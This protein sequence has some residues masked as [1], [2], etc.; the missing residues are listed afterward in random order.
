MQRTSRPGGCN[1]RSSFFANSSKPSGYIG[2]PWLSAGPVRLANRVQRQPHPA[3]FVAL[4]FSRIGFVDNFRI[5]ADSV[6]LPVRVP[7]S[8]D[9][10]RRNACRSFVVGEPIV[11]HLRNF[12]VLADENEYWRA[13]LGSAL[14]PLFA[15][16]FPLSGQAS[17]WDGERTSEWLRALDSPFLPPRSAG[18]KLR[19]NPLPDVEVC[20]MILR[21]SY[22]GSQA[23][24]SSPARIQSHQSDRSR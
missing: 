9:L 16:C 20:R 13:R 5:H 18:G 21:L 22:H 12:S 10:R 17:Q 14:L 23:A 6:D 15:F 1:G 11:D 19:Q 7:E 8:F 3:R 4:G 2:R 24:E